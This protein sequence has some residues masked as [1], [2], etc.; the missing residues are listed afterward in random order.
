MVL[1]LAIT[2]PGYFRIIRAEHH[3]GGDFSVYVSQARNVLEHR[4]MYDTTYVVTPQSVRNHPA[5]YPPVPSLVLVP[6]YA[7]FGL[8]Y[9]AFKLVLA[10]FFWL[11]LPLWY[12]IGCRMGLPEL[13]SAL[14]TLV[15]GLGA[16][17]HPILDAVGS[18]GV[19]MFFSA[20][21]LLA[22]LW[23]EQE[24]YAERRPIAAAGLV[25]LLLLL[26]VATRSAGLALIAAFGIW[27][28][29]GATRTRRLRP[30]TLWAAGLLG[31]GFLVYQLFVY[32][33]TQQYGSQ[34]S[35]DPRFIFRN[36]VFYVRFPAQLWI[37]AP[38]LLRY[39]LSGLTLVLAGGALVRRGWRWSVVEVYFFVFYGM[40]CAY[41]DDY[42][43]MVPLLPILLFLATAGIV[44]IAA[45]FP[46][47][48]AVA[49]AL[50]ILALAG[51]GFNLAAI[52]TNPLV[53]GVGKPAFQEAV[54]FLAQTSPDTLILSWNPR[55]FAFYTRRPSALY[56]QQETDFESQIPAARH[57]MLVEYAQPLDQQ[58]L[59]AYLQKVQPRPPVVFSNQEF[60]VYQLK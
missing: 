46:R 13:A 15:L 47:A 6:V 26:A 3:W 42:R 5:A 30:Y 21:A 28:A 4:P 34:L 12:R 38:D 24:G 48:R 33:S 29:I 58:K 8:N 16:A 22:L 50:G 10:F 55:V 36:A 51:S 35:L 7:A 25:S 45:N 39:V 37:F 18:D 59:G 60:R 11:S 44:Y 43:Y 49:P 32:S 52:E 9:R 57:V 2:A 56:P 17:I 53:D 1:L 14:A 20:A 31:L 23:V 54:R 27:E 41:F 19:Y 40:V